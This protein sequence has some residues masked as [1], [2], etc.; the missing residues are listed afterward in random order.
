MVRWRRQPGGTQPVLTVHGAAAPFPL[1]RELC[2]S[3]FIDTVSVSLAGGMQALGKHLTSSS[4]RLVQNCLWTLRNLSD[5]ATKQVGLGAA[6]LCS[7]RLFGELPP[8]VEPRAHARL[9]PKCCPYVALH[10]I[11][12]GSIPRHPDRAAARQLPAP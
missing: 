3:V 7:A 2:V 8:A 6:V 12:C 11:C 1:C 5:V 4:P 9:I 10:L